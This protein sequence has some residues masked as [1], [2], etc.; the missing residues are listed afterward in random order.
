MLIKIIA[1]DREPIFS[2]KNSVAYGCSH[3]Q[4]NPVSE[5]LA[6]DECQGTLIRAAVLDELVPTDK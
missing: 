5:L 4:L 2:T 1:P 6:R 3:T